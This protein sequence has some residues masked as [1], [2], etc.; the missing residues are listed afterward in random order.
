MDQKVEDQLTKDIRETGQGVYLALDPETAD[1]VISSIKEEADKAMAKNI[2][3][4]L[5]SSPTLRRHI[6]RM[7]DHFVPSLMVL[8]QSELLS[9]MRFKSIGEV[10][11]SYGS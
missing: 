6:K 4:I 3:P 5:L 10:K 9:E 7:A 2:Q 11:L 8:S 1:Q